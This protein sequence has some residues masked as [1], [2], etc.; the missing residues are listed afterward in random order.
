LCHRPTPLRWDV[1]AT[2]TT[3]GDGSYS[4]KTTRTLSS[5]LVLR[6]NSTTGS[7]G[8]LLAFAF[9]PTLND[10]NVASHAVV[11]AAIAAVQSMNGAHLTH[12]SGDEIAFL[13]SLAQLAAV[14]I[15]VSGLTVDNAVADILAII[16][17]ASYNRAIALDYSGDW[18]VNATITSST[19]SNNTGPVPTFTVTVV[20]D[21]VNI[22]VDT[23]GTV[24]NGTILDNTATWSGT[25][26]AGAGTNTETG[27]ATV[28]ADGLSVT[29]QVTW[30]H[31][32][33]G[34][35]CGGVETFTAVKL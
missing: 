3:A 1:I 28:S 20:Q 32:E 19:C 27:T 23:G 26:P 21:G 35:T 8:F 30:E 4:L 6:V 13:Y 5:N 29:G 9:N 31:T 17:M 15:D 12:F 2:T 24:L 34:I 25:Y 33:P 18:Q 14:S 11:R 7:N 16:N 22:T 10:I